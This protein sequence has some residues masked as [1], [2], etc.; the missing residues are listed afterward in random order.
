M[1]RHDPPGFIYAG[2]SGRMIFF[3]YGSSLYFDTR[4]A[5]ASRSFPGFYSLP[6][7]FHLPDYLEFLFSPLL[8]NRALGEQ[9]Y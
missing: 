2:L 1:Y 4:S 6:V 9:Y 3:T 7:S 8:E 5:R